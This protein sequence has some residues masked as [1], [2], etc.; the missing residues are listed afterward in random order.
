MKR[1]KRGNLRIDEINKS[2]RRK[3]KYITVVIVILF[4]LLLVG[5]ALFRMNTKS[6]NAFR[7]KNSIELMNTGTS[8]LV[9]YKNGIL[10]ATRDGAETISADGKQVWNVSYNMK[11]PIVDVRDNFAVIADMGGKTAYIINGSGVSNTIETLYSIVEVKVATQGVTSILMNNGTEDYINVYSMESA[12]PLLSIKTL[13]TTDGFPIAMALSDDGTKLVTSYIKI[14]N[15][16]ITSQVT[17]RNFGDVGKNYIDQVVGNWSFTS[18]VPK[19]E[20]ITKDVVAIFLEDGLYLYSMKE[21]PSETLKETYSQKI[22]DIFYT[23]TY[24]GVV[25]ESETGEKSNQIYLY[26]VDGNKIMSSNIS[27]NYSS[28]VAGEDYI[29]FYNDLACEVMNL[30]GKVVFDDTFSIAVKSLMKG[31]NSKEFFTVTDIGIDTLEMVETK[32]E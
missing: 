13:A 29:I 32:E 15:D 9:Q 4:L 22:L 17:F 12:Q 5:I 27:F 8:K 24:I 11:N 1:L 2:R 30:K 7:V 3:L 21:T 18:F 23:D 25:L 14:E 10:R 28:I 16:T 19:I 26:N 20:F 31:S 6:Y